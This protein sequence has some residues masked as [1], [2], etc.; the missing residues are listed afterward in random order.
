[1]YTKEFE[2][3]SKQN[4]D[5]TLLVDNYHFLGLKEVF[6][7]LLTWYGYKKMYQLDGEATR[8]KKTSSCLK[9]NREL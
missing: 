9:Y 2:A 5:S 6:K 8:S 7:K 4:N 3:N 1:M